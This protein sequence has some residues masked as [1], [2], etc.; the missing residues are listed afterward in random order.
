MGAT[1]RRDDLQRSDFSKDLPKT[2]PA[3]AFQFPSVTHCSDMTQLLER[4]R[5]D[6]SDPYVAQFYNRRNGQWAHP[7]ATGQHSNPNTQWTKTRTKK[8]IAGDFLPRLHY[9]LCRPA[10]SPQGSL[11]GLL[12]V[13][14]CPTGGRHPRSAQAIANGGGNPTVLQ[15]LP[16]T[17]LGHRTPYGD[18]TERYRFRPCNACRRF[19]SLAGVS[20]AH[21]HRLQRR[22]QP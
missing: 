15:H 18:E 13:I 20:A 5:K 21:G 6:S 17:R 8:A 3:S 4:I 19:A 16:L 2:A 11:T 7:P 22:A 9:A 14:L 12:L 1:E 10:S